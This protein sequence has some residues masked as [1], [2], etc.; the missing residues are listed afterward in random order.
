MAITSSSATIQFNV[1]GFDLSTSLPVPP[2]NYQDT[3]T[4]K[5]TPFLVD[6]SGGSEVKVL[7]DVKFEG[8][9]I[10]KHP[11]FDSPISS[12]IDPD[13][14]LEEGSSSDDITINKLIGLVKGSSGATSSGK[15]LIT[16]KY[17]FGESPSLQ[18]STFTYSINFVPSVSEPKL[19]FWYDT[20]V[21]NLNITDK[22][23]YSVGDADVSVETEFILYPPLNEAPVETIKTD[24]VINYSEFF[25]GANELEYTI[26]VTQGFG[27]Y[28]I[29]YAGNKYKPLLI[30]DIDRCKVFDCLKS[31]YEQW[32]GC[33]CGTKRKSIL[34]EKIQEATTLA[35]MI[36]YG[37]GCSDKNLTD[38]VKRF[39]DVIGSDCGCLSIDPR[40][41]DSA[42]V[43]QDAVRVGD[44]ISLLEN[45]EFYLKFGDNI[46]A[47]SNNVGYLTK[48]FDPNEGGEIVTS[49]TVDFSATTSMFTGFLNGNI[50]VNVANL[51]EAV[52]GKEYVFI[53]NA[54]D[55]VRTVSFNQA[56][57]APDFSD[58]S[59]VQI[60]ADESEAFRFIVVLDDKL[61]LGGSSK[62]LMR[63]S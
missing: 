18:S 43:L 29:I 48:V 41:V 63:I 5:F 56:F 32:R 11:Q 35:Q 13:V 40:F 42:S 2:A 33:P 12:V 46:S 10:Y 37:L 34:D 59:S 24:Q 27:S 16:L 9:R 31:L 3:I 4:P 19:T 14:L 44:N 21:P 50:S 1:G 30:Y 60:P 54:F 17:I 23:N 38:L 25:T 45:D 26:L 49:V 28:E 6:E 61:G 51:S 36:V 20:Q 47:L 53:L 55:V 15:Y 52:E 7:Y 57:V 8:V 22:A 58:L 62:K 39:N